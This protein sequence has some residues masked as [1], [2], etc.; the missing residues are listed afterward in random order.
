MIRD[1]SVSGYQ[2]TSGKDISDQDIRSEPDTLISDNL[3]T[4]MLIT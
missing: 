3:A 4:D 2:K 1:T